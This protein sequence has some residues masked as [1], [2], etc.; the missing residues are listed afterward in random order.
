MPATAVIDT[1]G[2]MAENIL[3]FARLLRGA[4]IPVG[5]GKVLDAITAVKTLGVGQRQDFYWCMFAL[6]V[7][8]EDQRALFDQAFHIFWR[9]PRIMDRMMGAM[10]PTI[11]VERED[12]FEEMSRRLSEAM[13]QSNT[14]SNEDNDSEQVEFDASFS[15]SAK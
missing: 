2:R 11:R 6:F 12:E 15:F 3:Y 14:K 4:G 7:N 9:N 10:L 8:R 1:E 5:P 13:G